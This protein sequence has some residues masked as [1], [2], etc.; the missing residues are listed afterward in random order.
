MAVEFKRERS[1]FTEFRDLTPGDVFTIVSHEDED[2]VGRVAM[3]IVAVGSGE[4]FCNIVLLDSGM[5][6]Y[7]DET[8]KVEHHDNFVISF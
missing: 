8:D 1:K 2:L 4:E 5:P 3:E 7:C 6:H